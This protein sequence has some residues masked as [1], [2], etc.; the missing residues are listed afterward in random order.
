M[1]TMKQLWWTDTDKIELKEVPI[2]EVGPNGTY[3]VK[4]LMRTCGDRVHQVT[5]GP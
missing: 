5:M 1:A 3:K 2:P 4:S